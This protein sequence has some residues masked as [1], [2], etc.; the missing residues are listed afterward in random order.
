[1]CF[2]HGHTVGWGGLPTETR[3]KPTRHMD[4]FLEVQTDVKSDLLGLVFYLLGSFN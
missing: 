3:P 2:M 4:Y 1:M